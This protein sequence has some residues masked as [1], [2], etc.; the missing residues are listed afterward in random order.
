MPKNQYRAVVAGRQWPAGGAA[1][2]IVW[3]EPAQVVVSHEGAA[4]TT[5]RLSLIDARTLAAML[6][7]A[8]DA[9]PEQ[10]IEHDL[11]RRGGSNP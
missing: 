2:L 3:R 7:A 6:L 10:D 4:V 9:G 5:A 8:A 11:W 1:T